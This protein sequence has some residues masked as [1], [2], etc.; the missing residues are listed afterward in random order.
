MPAVFNAANEV[1]VE[2]FLG[3][4]M[5]FT[6]ITELIEATLEGVSVGPI[7]SLDDVLEADRAAREFARG[8]LRSGMLRSA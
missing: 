1:A 4:A 2:A 3:G 6:R 7:R 5:P 8:T